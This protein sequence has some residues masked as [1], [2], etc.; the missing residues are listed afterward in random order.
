[1]STIFGFDI[2]NPGASGISRG[3]VDVP[4]PYYNAYIEDIIINEKNGTVLTY[5]VDGSNIG[6]ALVRIVPDDW[7]VPKE[8]L[9]RAYPLE[10]TIQDFPLV[11]EQVMVFKAYGAL[12]YSRKI[13]SK[14]KI[15]ENTSNILTSTF[16]E[17][18]P[19]LTR[20]GA[21]LQK[22]G[23]PQNSL[24]TNNPAN[25]DFSVN[26]NVRPIRASHG[27]LILQGRF[28]NFIRM[29]S[30]LFNTKNTIPPEPNILLTAGMWTSPKQVSTGNAVTA[31]SLAYENINEDKSSIW[32][33]ADQQVK[34]EAITAR[35]NSP[36]HLLSSE[37]RTTKYTGAQIFI[38]SDRVILNSKQNEISLFSK[39][40]INL[41]SIGCITLDTEK[42]IFLRS[43][44]DINIKASGSISIK[45]DEITIKS[46]KNLTYK[47]LGDY[48]ISGKRIFIGKYGD[49]TQPMVLGA[50]LSLWLNA[51]LTQLLTPGAFISMTGP[52][53]I[54]PA[55]N[56]M[57]TE[58]K[59]QLGGLASPQAAMFNSQDN[60]VSKVNT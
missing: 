25:G 59:S 41:S 49:V 14:R 7:N 44:S 26:Y 33:I 28:G 31:Y 17:Q 37:Q 42:N 19:Q 6:E 30:S 10:M 36:A 52:V 1:M 11:G 18:A 20:D 27:D 56:T 38:S 51:L 50:N 39:K 45:A 58:L 29:G 34:F 3:S 47:T 35:Q 9:R 5:R 16:G 55:V 46:E 22:Q 43:F 24:L 54:N 48:G 23:I 4:E 60:F 15:T 2:N 32:M 13:N 21:E 57:L 40:E 53:F 12:Y 8:D